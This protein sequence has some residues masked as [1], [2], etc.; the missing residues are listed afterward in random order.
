MYLPYELTH[1]TLPSIKF[2]ENN[3]HIP[4]TLVAMY[5]SL[6]VGG[7]KYMANR[8]AYSFKNQL[9]LWNISLS[10]FSFLGSIRM[11]P[12]LM[13]HFT[14]A[15]STTDIICSPSI[16]TW[17]T[18][19]SGLWTQLFIFSKIPELF[20]TF[21]IVARKKPLLFLHWYHHVTVL[22]YCWHSYA[23]QAPQTLPFITMNYMVHSIM[24]GYYG[25]SAMGQRP[26]WLD[27]SFITVA[28][29]TQMFVGVVVQLFAS[30]QYMTNESCPVN[31]DNIL[32][33][34]IMYASYFALFTQFAIKRYK[35]GYKVHK[36]LN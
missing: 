12:A 11:V 26:K 21:F 4:C 5:L 22:L 15:T 27:P 10:L 25:L 3:Y 30:Y 34:G 24:Y 18:G 6:I 28:Q 36:K 31:R 23:T 20:D 7:R 1:D 19:P 33:G 9:I 32:F 2:A 35:I 13:D 17:G 16:E 14:T 8:P 29:I